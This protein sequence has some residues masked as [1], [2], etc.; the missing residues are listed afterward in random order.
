MDKDIARIV[1]PEN[2][3]KKKI[4]EDVNMREILRPDVVRG[5]QKVI[6]S[7]ADDFMNWALDDLAEMEKAYNLMQQQAG[8][9]NMAVIIRNAEKLR[10]R[11]GTFGY[12]LGSQIAKSLALFCNELH[13]GEDYALIVIR[14]HLDGLETVF[15]A[16]IKGD[17]GSM[18]LELMDGLRKLIAK[19]S[20]KKVGNPNSTQW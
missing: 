14:Q 3:L 2:K 7:K 18:G 17:G 19:Y 11:S 4:G 8:R 20:G 6:N 5:A 13:G 15:R 16:N 1:R 10:D 12:Q 9:E